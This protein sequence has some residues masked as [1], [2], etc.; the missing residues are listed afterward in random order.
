MLTLR[1]RLARGAAAPTLR[2]LRKRPAPP[3][4]PRVIPGHGAPLDAGRVQEILE[5]DTVYLEQLASDPAGAQL[6][7][8][9]ASAAQKKIH[10]ANLTQLAS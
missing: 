1:G 9:R 2:R 10:D 7:R 3:A 8:S 5:Q 6:P 4:R